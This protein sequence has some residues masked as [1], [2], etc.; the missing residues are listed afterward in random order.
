MFRT[1]I[2]LLTWLSLWGDVL[3]A[4]EIEPFDP[5]KASLSDAFDTN[6]L[7]MTQS[8]QMLKAYI[9]KGLNSNF[10]DLSGKLENA[11]PAYDRRF[12]QIRSYFQPLLKGN[13]EALEAFSKAQSIWEES[14]KILAKPP[15]PQGALQLKENFSQMTLSLG[16]YQ[17]GCR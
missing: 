2:L 16:R 17:T 14:R 1:I 5:Q 10:D 8:Q 3:Y 11:L 6:C 15:T 4:L 13:P 7:Q 12:T 9:M